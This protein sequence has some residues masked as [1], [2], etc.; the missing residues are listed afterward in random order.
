MIVVLQQR[1]NRTVFPSDRFHEHDE[2]NSS[3][4]SQQK[5]ATG[6]FTQQQI[7]K[8]SDNRNSNK[9]QK[10]ES[11]SMVTDSLLCAIFRVHMKSEA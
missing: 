10:P 8:S 3:A 2:G 6:N 9:N 4:C 5:P 7:D 11:F 1:P